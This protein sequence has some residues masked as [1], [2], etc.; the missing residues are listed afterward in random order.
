MFCLI[1]RLLGFS[2]AAFLGCVSLSALA[3]EIT[4]DRGMKVNLARTP[5]RIVSLL[6][7]LTETVCALG[8]CQ[9]LVGVDRYSNFPESMPPLKYTSLDGANHTGPTMSVV[10]IDPAGNRVNVAGYPS[11]VREVMYQNARPNIMRSSSVQLMR[12]CAETVGSGRRI[13]ERGAM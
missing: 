2:I 10:V 13:H 7:S 12:N 11:A 1:K 8:Q 4:D 5:Q 3:G 6:P 9:R